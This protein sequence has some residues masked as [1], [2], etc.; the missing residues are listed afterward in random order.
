MPKF[1]CECAFAIGD[2]VTLKS[3]L[4]YCEPE[5]V[6]PMSVCEIQPQQCPGGIQVRYLVRPLVTNN[7]GMW[8]RAAY[9]AGKHEIFIE[10]ELVPFPAEYTEK[11]RTQQDREAKARR[12]LER[13]A[14][15]AS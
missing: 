15:D 12:D 10:Q 7:A 2:M 14:R 11:A 6:Q 1:E 4:D 13:A 3:M 8:G 9:A 5:N